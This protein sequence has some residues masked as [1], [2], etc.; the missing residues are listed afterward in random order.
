MRSGRSATGERR[1][2]SISTVPYLWRFRRAKS[3]T[4]ST[5]GVGNDGAGCLRS[6]RSRV[7]RLT[8]RSHA[9]PRR[10]PAFPP[11]ATP[12]ATR[13]WASRSVRRAQGAATVGRRSVKIRRRQRRLP[14]KPLAD[15][16]LEAHPILRPG[17][18]RQGAPIVTMDAPR[19]GG[20]QR[21][22]GAGLRRLHA[23]GDLRRGV[24]DLTRL[25][26]QHG[27]IR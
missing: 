25:E 18:V 27:R 7:L 14:A 19:W 9:W 22:G 3:S 15:A 4:P 16:Q 6:T 21:T 26:A 24:I 1:S 2:R 13:R 5:L 20:A 10:T 23:Q 11:S 17:Q 8:T 12:R